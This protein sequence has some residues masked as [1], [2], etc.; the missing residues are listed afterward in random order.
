M[1]SQPLPP[2]ARTVSLRI[3]K[4]MPSRVVLASPRGTEGGCEMPGTCLCF[5]LPVSMLFPVVLEQPLL[6]V[7]TEVK[8]PVLP[9]K[10]WSTQPPP[11]F[12][13][14]LFPEPPD[15]RMSRKSRR[16]QVLSEQC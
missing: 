4:E 12:V 15:L 6:V 3:M 10:L 2:D 16:S 9:Q 14:S 13:L 11:L 5:S 7:L 8:D 1:R